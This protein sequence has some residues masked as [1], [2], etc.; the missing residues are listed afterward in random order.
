MLN[1]NIPYESSSSTT[2]WYYILFLCAIIS[3]YSK[4]NLT[5]ALNVIIF[6]PSPQKIKFVHPHRHSIAL[7][8]MTSQSYSIVAKKKI[9]KS[10][11]GFLGY[12]LAKTIPSILEW[13][14][15]RK[16]NRKPKWFI[17]WEFQRLYLVFNHFTKLMPSEIELVRT[18]TYIYL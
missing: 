17:R 13:K 5:K 3:L 4:K 7:P 15:N 10:P 11:V 14:Y 1:A 18:R 2:G 9:S 8:K 12:F 16:G 6:L